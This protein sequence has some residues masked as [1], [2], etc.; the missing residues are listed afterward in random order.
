MRELERMDEPRLREV[1]IIIEETA[2][3]MLLSFTMTCHLRKEGMVRF[4]THF[5]PSVAPW[6]HCAWSRERPVPA[7]A[8]SGDSTPRVEGEL[9]SS[10]GR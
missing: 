4:G 1:D 9:R 6:M 5:T 10:S 3:D 2:K 7:M 8:R